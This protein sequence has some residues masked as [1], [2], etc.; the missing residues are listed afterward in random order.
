V[1]DIAAN[2]SPYDLRGGEILLGAQKLAAQ[3]GAGYRRLQ[4]EILVKDD[5]G[6]VI[7]TGRKR[8]SSLWRRSLF[9][10][11]AVLAAAI[12]RTE[13]TEESNAIVDAGVVFEHDF[14]QYTKLLASATLQSGIDQSTNGTFVQ[15]VDR[16][17]AFL[18]H[19][20]LERKGQGMI[21]LGRPPEL[22]LPHT[23]LFTCQEI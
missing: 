21:G 3:I 10:W 12:S 5:I 7:S 2:H 8:R 11:C 13:Q 17:E 14:N 6:A 22:G 20:S 4:T 23:I 9:F 15:T 16:Q 1:F 18:R 19:G